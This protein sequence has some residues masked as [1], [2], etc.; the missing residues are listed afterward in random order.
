ME[1]L[2]FLL[3]IFLQVTLLPLVSALPRSLGHR[4]D[5]PIAPK[6]MII[7]MVCASIMFKDNSDM[8]LVVS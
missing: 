2:R 4:D 3:A 5:K 6:V 1:L 7:S 8:V